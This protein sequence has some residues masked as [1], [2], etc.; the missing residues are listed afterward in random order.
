MNNWR[1]TLKRSTIAVL[2]VSMLLSGATAAFADG[3]GKDKDRGKGYTNN[4][5]NNNG[6]GKNSD[7]VPPGL[8]NK[9]QIHITF[10]DLKSGEYDWAL[11]YIASLASKKVFEGY[12]DGTFQPNKPISRIEAIT[13][14]IRLMGLRT[15]AESSEEMNSNLN[16]KDAK[17]IREKYPWATGYVAL[18]VEN[19]L[20]MENDT[21]VQPEKEASRLWATMLL[22]KALKLD[23][24]ARSKMNTKLTFKDA[25]D[26]P[27]GSVGY[28][29]VAIEKG[30]IDGYEDNTFRPNR[31]VT[32]AELAALLDRTGAQMPE[33]NNT[34]FSGT[35]SSV[36]NNQ[37]LTVEKDGKS[38]QYALLQ[39]ALILRK[40]VRA[41]V[42]DLRVGDK[43][44]VYVYNNQVTFVE[45]TEAVEEQAPISQT[46][47]G[48]VTAQVNNN[49][50]LTYVSN[51]QSKTLTVQSDTKIYRHG[52]LVA[53]SMLKVGDQI[54]V[55]IHN[56]QIM[57]IIVTTAVDQNNQNFTVDGKFQSLSINRDGLVDTISVTTEVYGGTQTRV[58]GVSSDVTIIGNPSLL[59]L[60]RDIQLKGT[61]NVVTSIEVK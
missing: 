37:V 30:L 39:D 59:Q 8:R 2:T 6:K 48:T 7:W 43:V 42:S 5:K 20:F 52:E 31:P 9:V 22:V 47:D 25:K 34:T 61:N 53:A 54:R 27:A 21:M 23:S 13:A 38:Q 44:K 12:E 35:L 58:Y 32:R 1:K 24:E 36:I 10:D 60:N 45:V 40:G 15:Q 29:A 19:D 50:V 46:I 3:K 51:N 41:N 17:Q 55:V 4:Q 14:A 11:R 49:N 57:F 33:Y 28:V 16:F 26:I 18:A 56:N